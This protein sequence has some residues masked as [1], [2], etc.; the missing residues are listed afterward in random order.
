MLKILGFKVLTTYILL[1]LNI[2]NLLRSLNSNWIVVTS[3]VELSGLHFGEWPLEDLR[4]TSEYG[5][6]EGDPNE[7]NKRS[8]KSFALSRNIWK[9]L[10]H[11]LF[12]ILQYYVGSFLFSKPEKYLIVVKMRWGSVCRLSKHR[13]KRRKA[14]STFCYT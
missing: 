11:Y 4:L 3:E 13:K 14:F 2:F 1:K 9:F 10:V 7:P 6:P 12:V 5:I 8:P